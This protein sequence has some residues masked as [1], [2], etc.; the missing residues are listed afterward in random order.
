MLMGDNV[1]P[2]RCAVI[3]GTCPGLCISFGPKLTE[4]FVLDVNLGGGSICDTS[5]MQVRRS[6]VTPE[7]YFSAFPFPS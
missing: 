7:D 6:A 4:I 5:G 1:Q 2:H 3:D